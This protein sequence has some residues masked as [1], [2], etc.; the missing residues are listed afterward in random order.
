MRDATLQAVLQLNQSFEPMSYTSVRRALCLVVNGKA[1]IIEEHDRNVHVDFPLPSVIRLNDYKHVP[2]KMQI[3]SRK[4]ILLRDRYVCQYCGIKFHPS[5][6]TLDHVIPKS[7]GGPA[8]WSNLVS[9]CGPCNRKKADKSL[10][11]S[12]LTLLRKPR[13]VSIHTSRFLIRSMGLDEPKWKPYLYSEDKEHP[14]VT[15]GVA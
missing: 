7:K 1:R 15:R 14:N 9:C 13:P 6:L 11:E 4:N 3:L 10:E 8:S 5:V 2:H 12:G